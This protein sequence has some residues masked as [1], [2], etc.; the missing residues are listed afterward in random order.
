[1]DLDPEEPILTNEITPEFIEII[2][3]QTKQIEV[4]KIKKSIKSFKLFYNHNS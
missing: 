1:M 4:I 3:E 2:D